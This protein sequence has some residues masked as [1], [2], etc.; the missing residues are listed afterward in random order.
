MLARALL[1]QESYEGP[2]IASVPRFLWRSYAEQLVRVLG[3]RLLRP[4][5]EER[6]RSEVRLARFRADIAYHRLRAHGNTVGGG[7][8][9]RTK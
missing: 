5:T 4:H 3:D 7:D 9:S 6:V 2:R 8:L 1:A